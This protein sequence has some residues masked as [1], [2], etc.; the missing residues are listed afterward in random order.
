MATH[1]DNEAKE[2]LQLELE[3]EV[4]GMKPVK[5]EDYLG[6]IADYLLLSSGTS[7]VKGLEN[8]GYRFF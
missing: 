6:Q 7:R 2:Q 5:R 8:K 1:L 3:Q 4:K